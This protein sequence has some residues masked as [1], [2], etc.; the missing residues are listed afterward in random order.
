MKL[1]EFCEEPILS[2][3]A[4]PGFKCHRECLL[5]QVIGSVAHQQGRCS[6]YGFTE[7]PTGLTARQDARA[8]VA[9]WER[10]HGIAMSS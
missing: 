1:C 8:A 6:C 2:G 5:R 4:P 9:L 10:T 3:E 7:E